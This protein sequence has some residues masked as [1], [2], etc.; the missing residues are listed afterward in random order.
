MVPGVR[1]DT[2]EIVNPGYAEAI[3][4]GVGAPT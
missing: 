2:F 1:D 4:D 3:A